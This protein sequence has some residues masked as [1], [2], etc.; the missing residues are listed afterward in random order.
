MTR[1]INSLAL[2]TTIYPGVEPF[3]WDWYCSAMEQTDQNYRLWIGLDTLEIGTVIEA[4]GGDPQATWI[5]AASGET[6][7]QIRQKAFSQI[8]ESCDG[9]VLVDSDDVLHA[10]RIAAARAALQESDLSGCALRLVDQQGRDLNLTFNL[11]PRTK[12]EDVLPRNNIFGLSNTAF[13]ADLLGQCLPIPAEAAL[14]DWFLA[15]RSWLLGARLSF[16]R[17]VR[18]DYR[19][20]GANMARVRFPFS[21]Q[22]IIQDTELV[23]RHFRIVRAASRENC[24]ADRLAELDRVAA[25]VEAFHQ[26]VVLQPTRLERYAG[27]LNA[28]NLVPL[29]WSCVAHPSLKHMW[30]SR[31][32]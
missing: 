14:V 22:Q 2:Y 26:G 13:R 12:P 28:L 5:E 11:P 9:V 32:I 20:H 31:E 8:V 15:T 18:M 23:R 27:A 3:L 17:V 16:D 6:P 10:S 7:A 21:L 1:P 4:M 30:A 19:Q 25:D 24:M 29:W